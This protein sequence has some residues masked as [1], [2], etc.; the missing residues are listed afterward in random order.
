MHTH[1]NHNS[2]RRTRR[3]VTAQLMLPVLLVL[4]ACGGRHVAPPAPF[5]ACPSEGQ[6]RWQQMEMNMFCHFG[7]NT[8]TD[9]E[10]GDGNE[11]E[12]LFNPTALDCRQWVAVAEQA[13]MGGIVLT[14][15][16]H[17]G[18]CLWPSVHST[19]T[20][21]Q[22]PWRDGQGDVLREL[23][24]ACKGH[25]AMGVYISPWDRNHPAYG[26]DA[27]NTV[28]ASTLLEVHQSYGPLFEQW[29]DGA[30]GE[31]PNGKRQ[32]YDWELF[33]ATVRTVNPDVVIFSDVGPGC[34]WVGNESGAAGTTCWSTLTADGC[35]P[36]SGHPA[37]DTLGQGMRM[38]RQWIPAECDV[39]IRD[40]W[41][42]H[43]DEEPKPLRELLRIYY[44]SV[45]RNALLLLN[46]P[47]DRRGLIDAAD[48]ARLMELR[49][50]IDSIFAHDLAQEAKLQASHQRGGRRCKDFGAAHLTDGNYDTYWATDD[51]VTCPSLLVRFGQAV[52]LNRV[53][54]QEYIPLGQRV[55][56]FHVEYEDA[57]GQWQPLAAGTTIG[58]RRILCT[59]TVTTRALRLTIDSALACP[60]LNRLGLYYDRIL[61]SAADNPQ[62]A[63]LLSQ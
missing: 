53:L 1:A 36:G 9:K 51:S 13:G 60:T 18:F 63:N 37:P 20:V 46:V 38:G 59:P 22:S 15:K 14:A 2:L 45:G 55:E 26:S 31:G 24:T 7:P 62:T 61:D 48:S 27:Y 52:T 32:R 40:G 6:L 23:A 8:F 47:P 4:T 16:H 12:A 10:W 17:D 39:S 35:E 57:S 21:A 42:W 34:R 56:T 11:A 43:R 41:F 54:L 19:H 33:N 58:Y 44:S 28:F 30:N 50:A 29:L 49:A 3:L 25:V 5:G